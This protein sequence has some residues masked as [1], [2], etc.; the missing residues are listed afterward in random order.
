M[1]A[2]RVAAEGTS[3][4]ISIVI[5]IRLCRRINKELMMASIYGVGDRAQRRLRTLVTLGDMTDISAVIPLP[6]QRAGIAER[7]L[8]EL[9]AQMLE[10][11]QPDGIMMNRR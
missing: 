1:S 5:A 7:L 2:S 6:G 10:Q 3:V 11:P 9:A 8:G 4:W